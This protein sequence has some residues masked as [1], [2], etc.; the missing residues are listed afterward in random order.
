MD[1][2]HKINIFRN[3][4]SYGKLRIFSFYSPLSTGFIK[5]IKD[6]EKYLIN[7]ITRA[8]LIFL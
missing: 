7:F 8:S 3:L 2:T 1:L 5:E 4:F 6:N